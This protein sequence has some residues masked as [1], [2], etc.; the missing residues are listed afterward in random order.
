MQEMDPAHRRKSRTLRALG[1]GPECCAG[2]GCSLQVSWG[3]NAVRHA[4]SH[5]DSRFKRRLTAQ[6]PH[7]AHEGLCQEAMQAS[8]SFPALDRWLWVKQG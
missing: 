3:Q 4:H 2:P 5:R 6:W 8:G 1:C 7:S